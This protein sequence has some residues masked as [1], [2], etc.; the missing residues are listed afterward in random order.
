MPLAAVLDTAVAFFGDESEIDDE[1]KVSKVVPHISEVG[2]LLTWIGYGG[3]A[4]DSAV[5]HTPECFVTTPA[6]E[7]FTIEQ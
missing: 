1:F 4:G 7:C 6:T 5:L 2:S 3:L